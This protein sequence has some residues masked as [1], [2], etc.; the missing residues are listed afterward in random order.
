MGYFRLIRPVNAVI[1]SLSVLIGYLI[2]RHDFAEKGF[3]LTMLMLSTFFIT[4]YGNVINDLFDVE[5]D[6]K[7][8]PDRAIPSGAVVV[9]GAFIFATLLLV[10]GLSCSRFAGVG[11]FIATGI[12]A[13]LL[14]LYSAFLKST[15]LW[16]NMTIAL[17]SAAT[18]PYGAYWAGSLLYGLW[19]FLFAYLLHLSREIVKDMADIEGDYASGCKTLPIRY[20]MRVS[21]F[22]VFCILGILLGILLMPW[23]YEWY[24]LSY[25]VIVGVGVVP[26]V[27]YTM[28][29]LLSELT[30]S[31]LNNA[32]ATL[33]FAMVAGLTAVLFGGR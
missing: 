10:V 28:A 32:S 1:A 25:V 24:G 11:Y 6:K 15:V 19:P 17:L 12:I 16:G 27:G 29:T 2:V 7:N 33:K 18:I 20:G 9:R 4:A 3:G 23:R 22:T 14:W 31:K 8:R 30:K 26:P 5:T 13:F 21:I